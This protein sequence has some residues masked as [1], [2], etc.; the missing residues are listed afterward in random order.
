MPVSNL[1][2]FFGSQITNGIR[3]ILKI[4]PDIGHLPIVAFLLF[5]VVSKGYASRFFGTWHCLLFKLPS[6]RH[7]PIEVT[8][9]CVH[10]V[11]ACSSLSGHSAWQA[12]LQVH[13]FQHK[14]LPCTH[15]PPSTY[16]TQQQT[17]GK[18]TLTPITRST[19]YTICRQAFCPHRSS[20]TRRCS[21]SSA[22]CQTSLT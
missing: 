19:H 8:P 17:G 10:V 14:C 4:A 6:S 5:T 7:T 20:G 11:C 16:Q 3:N 2:C 21:Q 18:T 1:C 22:G 13:H 12:A 9:V 15:Q